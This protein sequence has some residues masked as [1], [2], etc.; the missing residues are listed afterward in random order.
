MERDASQTT[1]QQRGFLSRLS[2][3]PLVHFLIAGAL[4]FAVY[5]KLNT[6]PA[7]AETTTQ[8]ILTKDDIF[9]LTKAMLVD[10]TPPTKEQMN[11]L[12]EQRVNEEILFREALALGLHKNDDVV[13]R[14]VADKMEFL[15]GDMTGLK[16][17]STSELKALFAKDPDRFAIPPRASFRHLYFSVRKPDARNRAVA[18]LERI[19]NKSP[20]ATDLVSEADP[21]MFQDSYAGQNQVQIAKEF[22][23]DFAKAVFQ[24]S[25]GTWQGPV[26][27]DH[28]WHLVFVYAIESRRGPPFE[29]I[30]SKVKSAWLDEKQREIR[31][32][33]L[34]SM[35]TRYTVTAPRFD[36]IDWGNL[37]AQAIFLD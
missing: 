35:R 24:L 20:D 27:S 23:L 11:A 30:E 25:S 26:Q 28:G 3:E 12:I 1:L 19:A 14:R 9:Q 37:R 4:I 22:G 16:E 18:A 29:E 6:A 5:Q 8:I 34:Q 36:T 2:R 33:A 32:M 15:I 10:G 21:F 13:R 31:R 17:P 7:G